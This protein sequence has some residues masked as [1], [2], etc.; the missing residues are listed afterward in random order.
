MENS[1][2]RREGTSVP[3]E[4]EFQ[5]M[6]PL[7][8]WRSVLA[9]LLI[10][11]FCM[12]GLIGLGM[13]FGGIGMDQDTSAK[14]V[15][16]FSGVWFVASVLISIFFGSYFA[17]RVSKFKTGRIG[18]AQG[19]VIA[20]LFL[21]FFFYQIISAI[22]FAGQATGSIIAK[23]TGVAGSGV[24]K[25]A[26]NPQV[27]SV[28]ENALGD[29]NLRSEPKQVASE[30]ATRLIRG[31]GEGAKN[32]LARQAGIT[33]GEADQ[34]IAQLRLQVDE[35]INKIKAATATALESTGW[36]IF[37]LVILGALASV[38]GGSLGS[39]INFRKPLAKRD[40]IGQEVQV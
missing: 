37:L 15:G 10:A 17:A 24:E 30:V 19:L 3:I 40:F 39:V 34:R 1:I 6:H 14:S 27:G 29:L 4:S 7:L 28:I 11:F 21:G 22:G 9:G 33:P 38:L 20:A 36:T 26:N 8:S 18:S 32:Y 13:A 25:M 16:I 12:A 2:F 5:T 35:S 31:D 23:T